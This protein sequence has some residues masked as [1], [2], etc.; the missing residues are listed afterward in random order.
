MTENKDVIADKTDSDLIT[1][2]FLDLINNMTTETEFV[3]KIGNYVIQKYNDNINYFNNILEILN[4]K[5]LVNDDDNII[6]CC[7]LLDYI[8]KTTYS[9]I[10]EIKDKFYIY[11]KK[12]FPKLAQTLNENKRKFLFGL[13]DCW[14]SMNIYNKSEIDEL[15]LIMNLFSDPLSVDL[16]SKI[17][18]IMKDYFDNDNSD[19]FHYQNLFDLCNCWEKLKDNENDKKAFLNFAKSYKSYIN[20][21]CK[22]LELMANY[23]NSINDMIETLNRIKEINNYK[24][25]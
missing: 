11:I 7:Y 14:C 13:L 3:N 24:I 16:D 22:N 4:F 23:I 21:E 6:K 2:E 1:F 9:V 5:L 8:I 18:N 12:S 15:K 25:E 20:N 17:N 10:P 19:F